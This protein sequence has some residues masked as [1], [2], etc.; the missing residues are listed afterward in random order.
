MKDEEIGW[1][2]IKSIAA[3]YQSIIIETIENK[4]IQFQLRR[5]LKIE[6][7]QQIDEFCRQHLKANRLNSKLI[8]QICF[9]R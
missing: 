8:E 1:P 9:Y 7:L 2:E 4:K 3:Q 6:E 5:N